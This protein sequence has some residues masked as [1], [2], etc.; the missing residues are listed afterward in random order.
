M[1]YTPSHAELAQHPK[2]RKLA[3]MLGVSI[4]T[5]LGHLH[6]LWHFVLKYAP[7]GD[8][9]RFDDADIAEGCMWE[10]DAQTL[11]VALHD[12]GF[13]DASHGDEPWQIRIHDWH[14]HGGKV[15]R[16]KEG[17]ADRQQQWRDRQKNVTKASPN[18]PVTVTSPL[19]NALEE[20]RLEETRQ[21]ETVPPSSPPR[22]MRPDPSPPSGGVKVRAVPKPSTLNAKELRAFEGWY[23]RYPNKQHRPEA[24]RAWKKL[25]PDGPTYERIVVDTEMRQ[26][27]RKWAEGYI[28]HPATY[29]RNRV[30]EDD[31][32]P[33]RTGPARASPNGLQ[34]NEQ[35][36][37]TRSIAALQGV[38]GHRGP[39]D[40]P[41]EH[42]ETGRRALGGS[43]P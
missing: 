8:I 19:Y 43:H 3:R 32:E 33:I 6:L 41:E 38:G 25:D 5:A 14:E 9:T 21:E 17:N 23:H 4:P 37:F 34:S 35:A 7:D 42:G 11:C 12:A 40:I 22:P 26:Q 2:T 28:E 10:S 27:G 16:Q 18:R 30:W 15:I 39:A 31:I 13:V 1:L 24:E 29:L 36:K 20:N